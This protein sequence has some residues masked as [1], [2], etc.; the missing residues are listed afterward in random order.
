MS[1]SR[2]GSSLGSVVSN[3]TSASSA[4]SEQLQRWLHATAKVRADDTFNA[5]SIT[6]YLTVYARMFSKFI[7]CST[8]LL[9]L[10]T[11]FLGKKAGACEPAEAL[12]RR[13]RFQ[14]GGAEAGWSWPSWSFHQTGANGE[15]GRQVS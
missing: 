1:A 8:D 13:S 7:W 6:S 2:P 15:C 12:D 4:S 11:V 14:C 9:N 3:G 10:C 5:V